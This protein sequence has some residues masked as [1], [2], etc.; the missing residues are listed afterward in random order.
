MKKKS[1]V[2]IHADGKDQ[3][4]EK[5]DAIVCFAKDAKLGEGVYQHR[6]QDAKQHQFFLFRFL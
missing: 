2:F 1:L 5:E 4:L 3:H 6:D